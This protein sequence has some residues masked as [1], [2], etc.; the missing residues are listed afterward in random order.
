MLSESL[1]PSKRSCPSCPGPVTIA[2]CDQTEVISGGSTV[3]KVC[4]KNFRL[5]SSRTMCLPVV[6]YCTNYSKINQNFCTQC[7]EGYVLSQEDNFCYRTVNNC[8][9]FNYINDTCKR[10]VDGYELSNNV[11]NPRPC[12]SGEYR[13]SSGLCTQGNIPNCLEYYSPS[14]DCEI[15]KPTF[16]LTKNECLPELTCPT[17]TKFS[18]WILKYGKCV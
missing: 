6:Y 7:M 2:N 16:T 8:L 12:L 3:C 5:H 10:C 1:K 17:I 13:N 9:M 18:F 14:G 4:K 11:C 15:C